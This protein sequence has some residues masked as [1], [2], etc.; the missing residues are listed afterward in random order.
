M[1][2]RGSWVAH[3]AKEATTAAGI[4]EAGGGHEAHQQ[5]DSEVARARVELA[6]PR[7]SVVTGVAGCLRLVRFSLQKSHFRVEDP[8]GRPAECG[9]AQTL[10]H[11]P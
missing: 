7:V 1:L 2:G 6:T 11:G 4:E 3:D 10:E 8:A 5:A 9:H